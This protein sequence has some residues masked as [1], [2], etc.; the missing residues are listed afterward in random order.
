MQSLSYIYGKVKY[1]EIKGIVQGPTQKEGRSHNSTLILLCS[2]HWDSF[3]VSLC[4]ICQSMT[5]AENILNQFSQAPY[6]MI[7]LF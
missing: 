3:S 2:S 1:N 6:L 7:A 4:S 5:R